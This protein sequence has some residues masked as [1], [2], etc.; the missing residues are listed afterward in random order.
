MKMAAAAMPSPLS[1]L[2]VVFGGWMHGLG[3]CVHARDAGEHAH[4]HHLELCIQV[5]LVSFRLTLH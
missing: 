4:H 2:V 5:Y 1:V 3:A